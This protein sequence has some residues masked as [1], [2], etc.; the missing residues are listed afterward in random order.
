MSVTGHRSIDEVRAYKRE[1]DNQKQQ[2][3]EHLQAKTCNK[4]NI[5]DVE[6]EPVTSVKPSLPSAA[7]PAMQPQSSP[8]QQLS[9]TASSPEHSRL[10]LSVWSCW[11]LNLPASNV[12]I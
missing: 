4:E 3:S 10:F 7:P 12:A 6:N 5:P 2:L 9:S 11:H 8:V 1:S